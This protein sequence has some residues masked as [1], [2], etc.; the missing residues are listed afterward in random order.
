MSEVL[1]LANFDQVSLMGWLTFLL[2]LAGFAW[3]YRRRFAAT[4]VMTTD[5]WFVFYYVIAQN[6]LLLPLAYSELNLLVLGDALPAYLQSVDAVTAISII[7]TVAFCVGARRGWRRK[8]MPP[9]LP[10]MQDLLQRLTI[11]HRSYVWALAFLLPPLL[12]MMVLGVPYGQ[13]RAMAQNDAQIQVLNN[14]LNSAVQLILTTSI[15]LWYFHRSGRSVLLLVLVFV[16]SFYGGTRSASVWP[17][18]LSG[19]VILHH[20]R[21]KNVLPVLAGAGFLVWVSLFYA[22]YRNQ[23][24]GT[25]STNDSLVAELLFGGHLTEMRDFVWV[26]S[27]WDGD[28]LWGKSYLAGLLGFIPSSLSDFRLEWGWGKV[29]TRLVGYDTELFSGFRLPVFG[30]VFFNFSYPG[31][32]AVGL[33]FGYLVF[34][35]ARS[36]ERSQRVPAAQRSTS[37]SPFAVVASTAIYLNLVQLTLVSVTIFSVYIQLLSIFALA[38]FAK[39]GARRRRS[40]PS[41]PAAI[42]NSVPD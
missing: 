35:A 9:G 24:T 1:E 6:F 25:E 22:A 12:G 2:S 15:C 42:A 29:T 37:R 27:L 16:A 26:Y 23:A 31:V 14:F 19:A 20:R 30:E 40:P 34:S 32:I 41:H 33:V 36:L 5:V 21:F 8:T 10:L 28:Y 11:G 13:A 17:V 38:L 18:I 39:A 7:G 3:F 4:G